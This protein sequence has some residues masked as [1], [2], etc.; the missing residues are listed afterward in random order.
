MRG[1]EDFVEDA[2]R[3]ALKMDNF[4]AS[5]VRRFFTLDPAV[6]FEAVQQ[7]GERRLFNAH[8]VSDF[9]LREFVSAIREVHERAPFPLAES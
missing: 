2:F 5:V 4:A 7:S 8:P 9:F 3:A 1:A 6:G